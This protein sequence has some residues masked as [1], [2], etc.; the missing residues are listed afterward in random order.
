MLSVGMAVETDEDLNERLEEEVKP[1]VT[2]VDSDGGRE[3]AAVDKVGDLNRRI[4]HGGSP[5]D[6]ARTLKRHLTRRY[7]TVRPCLSP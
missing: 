4:F 2:L 5:R 7:R 1:L 3:I 6:A